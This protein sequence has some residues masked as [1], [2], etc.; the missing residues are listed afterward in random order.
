MMGPLQ[1]LESVPDLPMGGSLSAPPPRPRISWLLGVGGAC[2]LTCS[3]A[4]VFP[5]VNKST[6]SKRKK[7]DLKRKNKSSSPRCCDGLA[8]LHNSWGGVEREGF[9]W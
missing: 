6:R 9:P 5:S 8:S 7:M 4:S 3:P 1:A 2:V